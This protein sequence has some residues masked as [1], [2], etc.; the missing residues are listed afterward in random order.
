LV[1]LIF[2]RRGKLAHGKV[3][4]CQKKS[5][6]FRRGLLQGCWEHR[7]LLTLLTGLTMPRI[8]LL[9]RTVLPALLALMAL[10]GVLCLLTRL[11]LVLIVLALIFRHLSFSI[12]EPSNP[13]S[14]P[15]HKSRFSSRMVIARRLRGANVTAEPFALQRK[16]AGTAQLSRTLPCCCPRKS[17]VRK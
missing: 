7:S 13:L 10:T 16:T 11:T 4:A 12:V 8:L 2:R 17:A 1:T 3:S 9:A 5:P 15:V 6:A 14:T